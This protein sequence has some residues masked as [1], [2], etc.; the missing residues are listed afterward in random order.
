MPRWACMV[1]LVCMACAVC[2][3]LAAELIQLSDTNWY[4]K[5]SILKGGAEGFCAGLLPE[6]AHHADGRRD[7]EAQGMLYR[8]GWLLGL[9]LLSL[10][11][12]ICPLTSMPK[13]PSATAALASLLL[14]FLPHLA[15]LLA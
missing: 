13:S 11:A 15:P 10:P 3:P 6:K 7:L 1:C 8:L 12:F 9:P 14:S 4:E 2:V 5:F